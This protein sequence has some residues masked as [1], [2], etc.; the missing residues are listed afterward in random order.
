MRFLKYA[1][2]NG[3]FFHPPFLLSLLTATFFAAISTLSIPGIFTMD[4]TA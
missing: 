4:T 2:R 3:S 1:L